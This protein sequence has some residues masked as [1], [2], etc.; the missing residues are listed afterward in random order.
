MAYC[1][2]GARVH[3]N[4]PCVPAVCDDDQIHYG[5]HVE[6]N[7]SV[8]TASEHHPADPRGTGDYGATLSGKRLG[9]LSRRGSLRSST[10]LSRAST[11]LACR[12]LQAMRSTTCQRTVFTFYNPTQTLPTETLLPHPHTHNY[13]TSNIFLLFL[14]HCYNFHIICFKMIPGD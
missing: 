9:P 11:S 3:V 5:W 4:L 14:I 12:W 2:A 6:A 8:A 7:G 13:R 1:G 10:H